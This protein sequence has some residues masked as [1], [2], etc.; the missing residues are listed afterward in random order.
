MMFLLVDTRY[1]TPSLQEYH[2]VRTSNP[3]QASSTSATAVS[4]RLSL[5]KIRH[6]PRF[7]LII[8]HKLHHLHL[9]SLMLKQIFLHISNSWSFLAFPSLYSSHSHFP[10]NRASHSSNIKQ[11]LSIIQV[12]N[13]F[14]G[15][16]FRHHLK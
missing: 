7:N 11:L 6:L 16:F 4:S 9:Q 14:K 15:Y 12:C 5:L 10:S 2:S 13:S 3:L 1:P 8:R